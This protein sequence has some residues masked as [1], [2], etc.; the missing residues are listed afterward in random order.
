MWGIEATDIAA[1]G[2]AG[3]GPD[4]LPPFLDALSENPLLGG[5]KSRRGKGKT[6]V[7]DCAYAPL[8]QDPGCH[9][10]LLTFIAHVFPFVKT[11]LHAQ[12]RIGSRGF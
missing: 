5:W 3:G 9:G 12:A 7:H 10:C 4:L 6:L 1:L 11:T 2:Q 8:R